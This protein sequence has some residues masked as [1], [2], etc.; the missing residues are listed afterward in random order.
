MQETGVNNEGPR[1]GK[2]GN[3]K[4]NHGANNQEQP[5]N[6]EKVEN[7]PKSV[8]VGQRCNNTE[9][10]PNL[11]YF[12]KVEGNKMTVIFH[13]VLAPHFK[14]ETS[15]GDRIFIRCGGAAFGNFSDNVAEV[16][17]QR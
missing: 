7:G 3:V 12:A 1:K 5:N 14:F 15:Q 16:Q 6:D 2:S 10:K 9:E 13:A 11:E 8:G 4:K 17:L